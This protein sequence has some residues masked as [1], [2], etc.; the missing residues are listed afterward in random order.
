MKKLFNMGLVLIIASVFLTGCSLNDKEAE[1][2][3]DAEQKYSDK[4][5]TD[6]EAI[7]VGKD[8]YEK[9][10]VLKRMYDSSNGEIS[11]EDVGFVNGVCPVDDSNVC[12]Q[13]LNGYDE[14]ADTLV[15][16]DFK[17]A[18]INE[19]ENLSRTEDGK[20]KYAKVVQRS[21]DITAT[22]EVGLFVKE[23]DTNKIVFD[24]VNYHCDDYDT[25]VNKHQACPNESIKEKDRNKYVIVKENDLWKISEATISFK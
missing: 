12:Y 13:I 15:T 5:L 24:A 21:G 18:L 14:Y 25:Y 23:K 4:V 3:T 20:V 2:G 19:D 8:L 10:L 6:Q 22:G 1:A 11:R 9:T 17:E 7:A 16:K